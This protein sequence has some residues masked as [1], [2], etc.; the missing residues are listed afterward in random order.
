VPVADGHADAG[1]SVEH[2]FGADQFDLVGVGIDERYTANALAQG[3]D[4]Q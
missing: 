4:F 1:I 2:L 3:L